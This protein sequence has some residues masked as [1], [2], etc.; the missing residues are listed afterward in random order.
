M[1]ST[2]EVAMRE[3]AKHARENPTHGGHC[4]CKDPY[5]RNVRAW[6]R[7]LSDQEREELN[8]LMAVLQRTPYPV[9]VAKPR[10]VR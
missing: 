2:L 10:G 3:M 6:Y 4:A 1:P 7:G 8:Y 9:Q 5:L